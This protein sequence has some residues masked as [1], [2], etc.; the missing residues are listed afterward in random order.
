LILEAL[1]ATGGK[2]R[3]IL[4][5][6]QEKGKPLVQRETSYQIPTDYLGN[7]A[8]IATIQLSIKIDFDVNKMIVKNP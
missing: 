8:A 1:P 4:L 2:A 5:D 3:I 6:G 7:V